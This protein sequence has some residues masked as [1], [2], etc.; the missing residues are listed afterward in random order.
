MKVKLSNLKNHL[1]TEELEKQMK[2]AGMKDA[3]EVVD[4][5][6]V[7]KVDDGSILRYLP[8]YMIKYGDKATDLILSN[9]PGLGW[10]K[11]LFQ[12]FKWGVK[13]LRKKYQV[14]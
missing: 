12:G 4:Y 11:Y 10:L 5:I 7:P 13:K 3:M 9:V 1:T 6:E 2:K 14:D 8:Y